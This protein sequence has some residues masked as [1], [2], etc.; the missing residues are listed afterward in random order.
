VQALID[1]RNQLDRYTA[2]DT[3]D[4]H[5]ANIASRW[6]KRGLAAAGFGMRTGEANTEPIFSIAEL[7]GEHAPTKEEKHK[8]D[9]DDIEATPLRGEPRKRV[10][11]QGLNRPL[12][13]FDLQEAVEAA[14]IDARTKTF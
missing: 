13:H 5:F 14:V 8:G 9:G 11:V 1:T 2:P 7:M 6:T 3:V 10:V 12:F 4:W